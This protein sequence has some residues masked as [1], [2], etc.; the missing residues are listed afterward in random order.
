MIKKRLSKDAVFL[1]AANEKSYL[2]QKCMKKFEC[3]KGEK[4]KNECKRKS[5]RKAGVF[6]QL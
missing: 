2:F 5:G 4:Q 3:F 1:S 6:K